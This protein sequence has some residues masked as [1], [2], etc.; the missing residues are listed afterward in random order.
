MSEEIILHN[1]LYIEK[2][3]K[4]SEDDDKKCVFKCLLKPNSFEL[5]KKYIDP[6]TNKIIL[7]KDSNGWYILRKK[8]SKKYIPESLIKTKL[9]F[10]AIKNKRVK[11]DE[12]A[13]V[14]E[15]VEPSESAESVDK[16]STSS[17]PARVES[18]VDPFVSNHM[19]RMN[20]MN[21]PQQQASLIAS[22]E[23]MDKLKKKSLKSQLKIA[24]SVNKT[25]K[26]KAPSTAIV[27]SIPAP[28]PAPPPPSTSHP[29]YGEEYIPRIED[30]YH[31]AGISDEHLKF[32]MS[33]FNNFLGLNGTN[34]KIFCGKC[35]ETLGFTG[36]VQ[37]G[38]FLAKLN[39]LGITRK[40]VYDIV[41]HTITI[42]KMHNKAK[43]LANQLRFASLL[44]LKELKEQHGETVDVDDDS[45]GGAAAE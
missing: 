34:G 29:S 8:K 27:P 33:A 45:D 40:E 37:S 36:T 7:N 11:N 23:R 30:D 5:L 4:T 38:R 19:M 13:E 43:I 25:Q 20:L 35:K 42:R 39:K 2:S 28:H 17:L 16:F 9:P 1:S 18:G 12:T 14:G 15:V 24:E 26:T 31:R 21:T 44:F 10:G 32:M 6:I 22:K 3:F 41:D